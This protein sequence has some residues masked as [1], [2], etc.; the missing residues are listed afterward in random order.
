MGK[1]PK[2]ETEG[3]APAKK[4]RNL[5][6][7][8]IIAV[9]LLGAGALMGGKG[10]G[11]AAASDTTAESTTTTVAEGPVV[12]LEPITLNLADGRFLKVGLA[13]Q[14]SAEAGAASG[15][16]GHGGGE[17]EDPT[18]HWAKALDEAITVFGTATYDHLIHPEGREAVK[19]ELSH[20]VEERYH[21]EVLGVYFTEF[22]MQ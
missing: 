21:G 1:K 2:N 15:G 13:L 14:L 18:A 11:S 16:G 9:A 22:V 8:I 19:T 20:R 10:G 7:A 3:E 6:P 12:A 4:S 17:A 5:L